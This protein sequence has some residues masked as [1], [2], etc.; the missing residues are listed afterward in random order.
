M[1]RFLIEKTDVPSGGWRAVQP[2]TGTTIKGASF[3]G[4]I[5]AVRKYRDANGLSIEANF[6]RQVEIQIC[7]TLPEHEAERK[8]RF[9]KE[10]D[11]KNPPS[12]RVFR[13][14][15]ED[16]KNF[17]LAV[18]EILSSAFKGIT[19]H[20]SQSTA[21]HRAAIC[22]QCPSNLPVANCWGCGA[23]G[24]LYREIAGNRASLKDPL[25]KSCDVCGCDNKT[26]IHYS[27]EVH[28]LVASKQGL[29]AS[30]FPEWCWKKEL[31]TN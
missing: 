8:C 16:L 5:A 4:L 26:Q 14:R 24:T 20:V 23:L 15:A 18:K 25:L 9:F 30:A 19:L 29:N 3:Q 13:S 1:K 10:D 6:R 12:V 21:N 11:A 31:L 7:D 27:P 17:A 28:R 22:A 2:E